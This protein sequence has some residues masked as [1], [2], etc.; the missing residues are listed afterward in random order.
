MGGAMVT[1][2]S[3]IISGCI[4]SGFP[5]MIIF[6]VLSALSA[7]FSSLLP[8]TLHAEPHDEI[9]ELR[10]VEVKSEDLDALVQAEKLA[11]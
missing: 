3:F 9:E 10:D 5:I 1:V 8:E 4:D 11:L 2:A 7:F 6:A